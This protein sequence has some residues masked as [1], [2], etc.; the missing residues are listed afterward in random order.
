M[1]D[2]GLAA[3]AAA[4]GAR[5]SLRGLFKNRNFGF[6]VGV[7]VATLLG[8][9]IQ[10]AAVMWQVYDLTNSPVALA[11]VGIARFAP[12][13]AISLLAGAI[14]DNGDRRRVLL[15]SQI[16]PLLTSALLAALTATGNISLVAIYVCVLLLGV[17]GAFEGPARSALLPLVVPRDSFQRAVSVATIAQQTA[18]VL[19]PAGA[20][21]TIAQSGV[22]P[23]YMFHVAW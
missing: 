22:A 4:G 5:D 19:G 7:R 14:T 17:S 13:L 10:A 12:S 23:A 1:D 15:F 20:G 21:L 8:Q 16:T 18:S 11:F 2:A 9:T 3:R 6:Y